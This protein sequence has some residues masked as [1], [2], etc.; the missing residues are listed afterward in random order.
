MT[1]KQEKTVRK[2]TRAKK[3]YQQNINSQK[4]QYGLVLTP[5]ARP[6]KINPD[7]L[8]N[9]VQEV[10]LGVITSSATPGTEIDG[11]YYF[12]Y[13]QLDGYSALAGTFDQYR[14]LQVTLSFIP[15]C[16]V[17]GTTGT[18]FPTPIGQLLT[19]LDYD[20]VASTVASVLRQKETAQITTCTEQ[21][22]R[23]LTPHAA[24]AAYS[25][26]FTSY[27]NMGAMWIDSASSG[28]Q[29]YGVKFA[30]LNCGFASTIIYDVYAR[31]VMQFR[32]VQ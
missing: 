12:Y 25:G 32:Q 16:N 19:A 30:V 6:L 22:T 24:L 3:G 4:N 13:G 31:Y 15:R 29:H 5:D 27:A 26:S 14:F 2:R 17:T 21:Q 7:Q 28:V 23:T 1:N 18:V 9:I 20:D 8:F 11:G 10:S